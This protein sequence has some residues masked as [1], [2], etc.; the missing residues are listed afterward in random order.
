VTLL[1]PLYQKERI[2][3]ERAKQQTITHEQ[4]KP[5]NSYLSSIVVLEANAK[6]PERQIN[7][8]G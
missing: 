7:P 5:V 3:E 8:Q 2:K 1:K 4:H 6:I